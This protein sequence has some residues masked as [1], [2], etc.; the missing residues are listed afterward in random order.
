MV[1]AAVAV[2]VVVIFVVFVVAVVFVVFAAVG[3]MQMYT[4]LTIGDVEH[5]HTNMLCTMILTRRARGGQRERGVERAMNRFHR[6]TH[7]TNDGTRHTN[8]N[9]T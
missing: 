6:V 9:M 3:V 2:F 1:A 7:R 4:K 8:Q 5:L